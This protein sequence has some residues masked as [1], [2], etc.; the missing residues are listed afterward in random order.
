M[1]C[2]LQTSAHS[3][4]WTVYWYSPSF[5]PKHFAK[6]TT[7]AK[8]WVKQEVRIPPEYCPTWTLMRWQIRQSPAASLHSPQTPDVQAALKQGCAVLAL[9]LQ[10]PVPVRL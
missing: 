9:Q 1:Y 5:L 4:Y 3:S 6:T 7:P 8:R 10:T 2:C